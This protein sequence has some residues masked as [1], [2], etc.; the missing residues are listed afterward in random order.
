MARLGQ[1]STKGNTLVNNH[2]PIHVSFGSSN[3]SDSTI[4]MIVVSLKATNTATERCV[5]YEIHTHQVPNL[6][7]F[8]NEVFVL[9]LI[10][11]GL[12]Y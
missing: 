11:T 7:F 8:T 9:Q 12:L 6:N 2:W 3:S 1:G 10:K 4:V 5:F